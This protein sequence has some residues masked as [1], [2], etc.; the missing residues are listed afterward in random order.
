MG[1]TESIFSPSFANADFSNISIPSTI[2]PVDIPAPAPAAAPAVVVPAMAEKAAAAEVV[3]APARTSSTSYSAPAAP[4]PQAPAPATTTTKVTAKS[5]DT[6]SGI[7]KANG[8]TVAQI[9]ADNPVLADRAASGSNVLFNGTTVKITQPNTSSNPYGPTVTGEGAGLGTASVPI[10]TVNDV[11]STSAYSAPAAPKTGGYS[12]PAAPSAPA[13]PETPSSGYSA[14]TPSAPVV[15]TP[16]VETPTTG[17]GNLVANPPAPAPA[18]AAPAPV[19]P[20]PTPVVVPTTTKIKVATPDIVLFDDETV[21]VEVIQDL[22]FEDIGGQEILTIS[23]SDTMYN[24]KTKYQPIKNLLKLQE[25]NN[26]L[27]ILP[28]QQTSDK[29]FDGYPIK[30]DKRLPKN[31]TGPNGSNVYIDSKTGNLV[32][33]CVNIEE[34]EQVQIDIIVSGTIYEVNI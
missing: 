1:L 16:A 4:A 3:A 13:V 28:I 20:T 21:P 10:S 30:L 27:N 25:A 9:L 23:R 6:L 31:P 11:L 14:P 26:P 2:G 24:T 15:E 7:A 32:V 19:A 12:A 17:G 29:H 34:K 22:L 33:E 5:G 8:T 18:P